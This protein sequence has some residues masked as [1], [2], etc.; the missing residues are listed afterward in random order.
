VIPAEKSNQ[1]AQ[2]Q[3]FIFVINTELTAG[4]E[5]M[6][7]LITGNITGSIHLL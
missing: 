7:I 5:A 6:F 4:D 2:I 3:H 1:I